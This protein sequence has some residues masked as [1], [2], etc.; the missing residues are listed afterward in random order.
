MKAVAVPLLVLGHQ[1]NTHSCP[2]LVAWLIH[3]LNLKRNWKVRKN[4]YVIKRI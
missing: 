2:N 1:R 4:K 3:N